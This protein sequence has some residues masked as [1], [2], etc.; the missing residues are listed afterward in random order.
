MQARIE[1][2]EGEKQN[3]QLKIV[4]L[5]DTYEKGDVNYREK[6][7]TYEEMLQESRRAYI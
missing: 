6:Q 1:Q 7:L 2:L 5:T 3:L 4:R